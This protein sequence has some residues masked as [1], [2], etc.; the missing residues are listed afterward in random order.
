VYGTAISGFIGNPIFHIRMWLVDKEI[1]KYEALKTRKKILEGR[2]LE[3]KLGK[4]ATS[5]KTKK[6]IDVFEKDILKIDDKIH[7][8]E[9]D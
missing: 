6:A 5:E 7:R 9:E 8:I 1:E 4:D 2:I 3:L